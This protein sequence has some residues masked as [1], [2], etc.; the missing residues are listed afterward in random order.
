MF[1]GFIPIAYVSPLQ[2]RNKMITYYETINSYLT[3]FYTFK[4]RRLDGIFIPYVFA[5]SLPIVKTVILR[6]RPN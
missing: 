4:I 6:L 1:Y 3:A 5:I 2:W